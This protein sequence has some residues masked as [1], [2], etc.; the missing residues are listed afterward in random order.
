MVVE[1]TKMVMLEDLSDL[2]GNGELKKDE[3]MAGLWRKWMNMVVLFKT[4]GDLR[5]LHRQRYGNCF[6]D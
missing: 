2:S 3:H 6:K 5:G 1:P 4:H